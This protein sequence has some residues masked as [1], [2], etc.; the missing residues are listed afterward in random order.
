VRLEFTCARCLTV[1]AAFRN[2]RAAAVAK[3]PGCGA[4]CRDPVDRA[5]G[6]RVREVP[7]AIV[8]EPAGTAPSAR[9][10]CRDCTR[11]F[12]ARA[13]GN[14]AL[15][16]PGCASGRAV[17]VS[18]AASGIG[19]GASRPLTRA[20]RKRQR[21]VTR[22]HGNFETLRKH[23]EALLEAMGPLEFDEARRA[24]VR[25]L[26]AALVTEAEGIKEAKI[27]RYLARLTEHGV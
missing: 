3:C 18:P 22:W 7:G 19:L 10:R 2:G 17:Q 12:T 15:V 14:V 6:M 1:F 23:A 26:V 5:G 21:F 27:E 24:E 25:A 9:F 8:L 11:E 4:L 20:E 13:D 16:C